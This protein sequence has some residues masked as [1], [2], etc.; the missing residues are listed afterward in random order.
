MAVVYP[1]AA[2]W[3]FLFILI[4]WYPLFALACISFLCPPY[5]LSISS[6]TQHI[7][8]CKLGYYTHI[9]PVFRTAWCRQCSP[10]Y[11]L[12]QRW[13]FAGL[14]SESVC[15]LL[16][17]FVFPTEHCITQQKSEHTKM[18]T[19]NMSWVKNI[20]YF[21]FSPT[22]LFFFFFLLYFY[23][24]IKQFQGSGCCPQTI[25]VATKEHFIS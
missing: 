16:L 4:L 8:H 10:L 3:I 5:F 18:S 19:W 7:V 15:L 23:N 17:F 11:H 13:L 9:F 1:L 6:F 2:R 14:N 20:Y 12:W 22:Y 24:E 21:S 25:N